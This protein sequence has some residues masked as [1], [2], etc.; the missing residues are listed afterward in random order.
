[1][2]TGSM[3][4]L[5][6]RARRRLLEFGLDAHVDLVADGGIPARQTERRAIEMARCSHV[7]RD[8]L[9][10]AAYREITGERAAPFARALEVRARE[11][12]LP[13]A[14]HI[15]HL[16]SFHHGV[17]CADV[18]VEARGVDGRVDRG[19]LET[20]GLPVER[21]L[22]AVEAHDEARIVEVIDVEHDA[23]VMRV[24]RVVSRWHVGFRAANA[25]RDH[26]QRRARGE[27]RCAQRHAEGAARAANE[28]RKRYKRPVFH[29][30]S[31]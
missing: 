25:V 28:R 5:G 30:I 20:A 18:G 8:R 4:L 27:T 9:R 7:E 12:D 15:Q 10:H 23:P 24:H 2:G 11:A 19:R 22:R 16:R 17:E 1:M 29:P 21:R 6:R 26:A 14:L 3:R 31:L 13:I